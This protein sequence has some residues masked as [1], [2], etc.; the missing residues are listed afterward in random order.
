MIV[1][2]LDWECGLLKPTASTLVV[3][4]ANQRC[5]RLDLEFSI[6]EKTNAQ[7]STCN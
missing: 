4:N 7:L 5:T 6:C 3:V 2:D 1:D